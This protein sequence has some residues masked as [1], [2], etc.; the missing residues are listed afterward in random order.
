MKKDFLDELLSLLASTGM[1]PEQYMIEH[2]LF[3]DK[4][5]VDKAFDEMLENLKNNQPI[6]VRKS[7]KSGIVY[8]K[9]QQH[10]WKSIYQN[11]PDFEVKIDSDGNREVRGL[12]NRLTGITI[13]QGANSSI[14]FS[15]ISHI[16][17]EAINPLF[18]TALWNIVIVPAYL[19]DVLDK[20]DGTH[21]FIS[22]I[23]E[24][25]KAICWKE[26]DVES[27]LKT[28]GL[29]QQ[30]VDQYV[31]DITVLNGLSFSIN[32][33][34]MKRTKRPTGPTGGTGIGKYAKQTITNLLKTNQL[35]SAEISNLEN[36]VFCKNTLGMNYPVLVNTQKNTPKEGRYYKI[37][38]SIYPY[39]ICNDWYERN[40]SKF[41]AWLTTI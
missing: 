5:V 9:G 30:E 12:I 7:T 20:N 11:I 36:P 6:P 25:Y 17:G 23:K 14:M 3:F 34:P 2:S 19:N 16:W 28:L 24:I 22:R 32:V 1:T 40:R 27:K 37:D 31:P 38:S 13:S 41:D 8:H 39:V 21:S 18:F 10:F 33:V 15:K 26:Y 35:T 29:T 4:T